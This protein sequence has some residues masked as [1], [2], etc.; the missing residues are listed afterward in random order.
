VSVAALTP[1]QFVTAV[2]NSGGFLELIVF[3]VNS[4]G[5]ITRNGT[6]YTALSIG[7]LALAKLD[8]QR[9]VTVALDMY[10]NTAA[11]SIWSVDSNVNITAQGANPWTINN[12]SGTM[13][14][15]AVNQSQIVVGQT[16]NGSYL[17][18]T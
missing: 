3:S 4:S 18:L 17:T 6:V 16:G 8:S 13:G 2:R 9:V 14:V 11:L 10:S 1:T 5:N 12:Y 7:S 15:V